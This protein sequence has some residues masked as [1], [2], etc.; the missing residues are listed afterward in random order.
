MKTIKTSYTPKF[1]NTPFKVNAPSRK[2]VD[3]L[4]GA[5]T[6]S[7]ALD[8]M[9]EDLRGTAFDQGKVKRGI[10]IFLEGVN[11]E[12]MQRYMRTYSDTENDLFVM[13]ADRFKNMFLRLANNLGDTE[14]QLLDIATG[15]I[16]A[17]PKIFAEKLGVSQEKAE[18]LPFI[19]KRDKVRLLVQGIE[20]TDNILLETIATAISNYYFQKE[21]MIK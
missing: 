1:Q 11:S 3:I 10:N 14:L 21:K 18:H 8:V 16:K 6:L 17:D 2:Q 9:L 20:P 4:K 13:Q 19:Q 12:Q 5:I 15:E 7:Y